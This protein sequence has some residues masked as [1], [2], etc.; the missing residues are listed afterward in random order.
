MELDNQLMVG[1][2]YAIQLFKDPVARKAF[3]ARLYNGEFP[4]GVIK[5]YENTM[6]KLYQTTPEI[7]DQSLNLEPVKL[8]VLSNKYQKYNTLGK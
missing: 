8:N 5:G 7:E 4:A 2:S 1:E 3:E 6:T